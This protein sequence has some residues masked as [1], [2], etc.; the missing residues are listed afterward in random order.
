MTIKAK[1]LKALR[2][3]DRIVTRE[4]DPEFMINFGVLPNPDPI[5][6][7]MGKDQIIYRDMLYDPH[8]MGEMRSLRSGLLGSEWR[9]VAGADD[10][11]SVNAFK[12]ISEKLIKRPA[13]DLRWSDFH[14]NIYNAI[15]NGQNVY[16]MAWD[17]T[18]DNYLFPSTLID[19]P[20]RRF[21]YSMD[22]ELKYLTRNSPLFGVEAPTDKRFLLTRHMA[23]NDNPYG[24]AVLSSCFWAYTFKH[25]GFKWF[26]KFVE[27]YG[28][29]WAIGRYPVGSD[30]KV[31][32]E[33]A[34][35]L[36]SMVEDAVAAIPEGHAVELL[37]R[38]VSGDLPQEKLINL[39]NREISKALTSQTLATEIQ[40][41]GGSRAASETHQKRQ[42]NIA[43]ADRMMVSETINELLEWITELNFKGAVAPVHEFYQEE[44]A[45]RE[46]AE[47]LNKARFYMP[48]S[49]NFA[50]ERL[51]I[52]PPAKG[53]LLLSATPSQNPQPNNDAL[54]SRVV[55]FKKGDAAQGLAVDGLLEPITELLDKVET[56]EEFEEGLFS[57]FPNMDDSSMA[58]YMTLAISQGYLEGR[59]AVK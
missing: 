38:K 22:N 33:L 45:R 49:Q 46:W 42:D 31:Q 2:F 48:I 1:L 59:E 27:K 7:K 40:G 54:F 15:F 24:V 12:V 23:N 47:V 55:D 14:W 21:R 39:C 44:E 18:D 51:Q 13:P 30:E 5:L 28:I 26:S 36:Q 53:E 50:Y 11:A 32:R 20:A 52:T 8:I 17:V 34:A 9:F 41:T 10:P 43:K 35:S 58:D 19:R 37:E 25:A 57:L 6:A 4:S 3:P 16:E 29:P 56:L